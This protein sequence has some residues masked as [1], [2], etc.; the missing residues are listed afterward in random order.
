MNPD[1][2]TANDDIYSEGNDLIATI[3]Y[4]VRLG[5]STEATPVVEV[6]FLETVVTVTVDLTSNFGIAGVT[7]TPKVKIDATIIQTNEVEGYRCDESDAALTTT[8]NQGTV[9]KI[10]VKPDNDQ[11]SGLYMSSIDSFS[12]E[13]N[14]G[15]VTQTAIDAGDAANDGLTI[16]G[17][18]CQ[19]QAICSFETLLKADFFAAAG[20]VTGSGAAT[21]QYGAG[22]DQRLLRS[23]DRNLQDDVAGA[24]EFGVELT[25]AKEEDT[26]SGASGMSLMAVVFLAGVAGLF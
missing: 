10:C 16:L 18:P 9:V 21:M 1:E 6:N 26:T 24:S 20:Q 19:G 7:A 13:K 22:T 17:A 4:C 3:N 25:I 5:L 15:S 12:W 11:A 23:G 14:N 8:I 2:I